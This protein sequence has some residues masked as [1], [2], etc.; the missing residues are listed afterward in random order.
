MSSY[1]SSC[2]LWNDQGRSDFSWYSATIQM[3]HELVYINQIQVYFS[4]LAHRHSVVCLAFKYT[5]TEL[6]TV[7]NDLWKYL[8]PSKQVHCTAEEQWDGLIT[9]VCHQDAL[10]PE[11]EREGDAV[12]PDLSLHVVRIWHYKHTHKLS[13]KTPTHQTPIEE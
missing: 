5:R 4:V 7:G 12:K 11:R 3:M 10:S 13:G 9:A 1:T 6:M 8:R 2:F